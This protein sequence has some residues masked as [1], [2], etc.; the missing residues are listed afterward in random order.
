MQFRA[1]NKSYRSIAD[2]INT[3]CALSEPITHMGVKSFFDN[4]PDMKVPMLSDANE[5]RE[6]IKSELWNLFHKINQT[7]QDRTGS[8]RAKILLGLA[9]L[10]NETTSSQSIEENPIKIAEQIEKQLKELSNKQYINIDE[11]KGKVSTYKPL[12]HI[13]DKKD[14]NDTGTS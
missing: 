13:K 1:K 9:S 12:P 6:H 4:A 5:E 8:A 14:D 2:W 10:I 11:A 3:N 7:G